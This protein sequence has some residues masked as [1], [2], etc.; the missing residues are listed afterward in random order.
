VKVYPIA[1][2]LVAAVLL[3]QSGEQNKL[4]R[5][6][7]GQVLTSD[8]DPAVKITF[9]KKFRYAGG[10]RFPL[11]GVAEA[12]QHFFVQAAA[13]GKIQSFYWLQFEHYLANN[14]HQYDYP[15]TRT[16]ELGGLTFVHDTK[17]FANYAGQQRNP[18]S[19][20]GKAVALLQ[21]AGFTL[22]AATARTRMFY[23][24]DTSKRK[25]LMIIYGEA[26]SEKDAAGAQDGIS[27]DDK[28][29]EIAAKIRA[30]ADAGMKIEK[31]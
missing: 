23:L 1:V 22:P 16:V 13:D 30:H 6:V 19:D 12:E 26:V 9:D 4:D 3:A 24:T 10:Q 5:Q 28:L 15:P 11:Y 21:K 27:A 31:K 14:D 2:L 7:Q 18:E 17:V 8:A 20:A 29:P 25:E